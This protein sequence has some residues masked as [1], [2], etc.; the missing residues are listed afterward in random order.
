MNRLLFSLLLCAFFLPT[1]QGQQELST[2]F[3]TNLQQSQALNPAWNAQQEKLTF[4]LPGLYFNAELPAAFNDFVGENAQGQTIIDPGPVLDASD[5]TDQILSHLHLNTVGVGFNAAGFRWTFQHSVRVHEF[6]EYPIEM[7]RVGWEGNAQY[8]G[9]T[10]PIGPDFQVYAYNE[11]AVGLSRTFG[12]LSIGVR[13]K[14]LNGVGD[15]STE[16]DQTFATLFTSDDIYQ[17]ELNTDYRINSS[18]YVRI[19]DIDDVDLNIDNYDIGEL[20]NRNAGWAID[21]G[22]SLAVNDQLTLSA[23]AVDLGQIVWKEAVENYTS[24]GTFTFEGLQF[25]NI[26]NQDSLSFQQAIDTLDQIFEFDETSESYTT[27][28]PARF[29]VGGTWQLNE[30]WSLG[31][32]YNLESFRGQSYSAVAVNGQWAPIQ[33]LRL[34]ASYAW[35]YERLDQLGLQVIGQIGPVQ[36]YALSDNVLAAFRPNESESTNGRVGLNLIF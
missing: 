25:D 1:L 32:L 17:L 20:F 15:V 34:G 12:K 23:S 19:N 2:W 26:F 11:F 14:Y 10:V 36:L 35:R 33:G 3:Y 31:A 13:G 24:A 21:L 27:S 9:E 6:L 7:L 16:R 5:P 30:K 28:L 4:T 18:A 8:I 22:A 29:F